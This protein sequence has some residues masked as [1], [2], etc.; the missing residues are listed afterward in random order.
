M[1]AQIKI[2]YSTNINTK[3]R[4]QISRLLIFLYNAYKNKKI[5]P[6]SVL[7]YFGTFFLDIEE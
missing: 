4:H 7:F 3:K 1:K 2:N 5:L 6:P